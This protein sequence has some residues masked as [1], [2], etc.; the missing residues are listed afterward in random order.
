MGAQP[1]TNLR[2]C[3][4]LEL[5]R[6]GG[7]PSLLSIMKKDASIHL[8]G[9]ERLDEILLGCITRNHY[10]RMVFIYQIR[11]YLRLGRLN[12]GFGRK[13]EIRI[14]DT[15]ISSIRRNRRSTP[16]SSMDHMDVHVDD[17][18]GSDG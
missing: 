1:D 11:V 12:R 3:G 10:I 6:T 5:N 9:L 15:G 16:D 8:E 13:D 14:L 4:D 17:D 18:E 2:R 7:G